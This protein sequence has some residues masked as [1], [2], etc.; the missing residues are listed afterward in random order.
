MLTEKKLDKF[1]KEEVKR[2][3]E[4]A[5]LNVDKKT[6]DEWHLTLK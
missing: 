1:Y 4:L 5:Q 2:R 3:R 6:E